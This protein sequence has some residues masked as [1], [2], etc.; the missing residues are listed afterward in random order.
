MAR[1]LV[2]TAPWIGAAVVLIGLVGTI[3][4]KGAV[5]GTVDAALDFIPFVGVL[6]NAAE[7]ARGRDFIRDR[8]IHR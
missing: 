8:E 3:R 5:G 4:R 7:V 6:K 1:R 2:R